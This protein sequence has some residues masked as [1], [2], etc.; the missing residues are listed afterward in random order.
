MTPLLA[1]GFLVW[2]LTGAASCIFWWTKE[3]DLEV[4][5]LL[6]VLMMAFVGPLAF[7][8]GWMVHGD[9]LFDEKVIIRKRN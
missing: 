1:I 2:L 6:I 5:D 7:F 3:F 4:G 8:I 9:S